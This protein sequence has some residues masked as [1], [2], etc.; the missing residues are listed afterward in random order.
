MANLVQ[1]QFELENQRISRNLDYQWPAS[2]KLVKDIKRSTTEIL[3]CGG[4]GGKGEIP[5]SCS[6]SFLNSAA[7]P[8]RLALLHMA[9]SNPSNSSLL[10]A[11]LVK[12]YS[13][14]KAYGTYSVP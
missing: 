5:D 13:S 10:P 7:P 14:D 2:E 12:V 1:A 8:P 3:E 11:R 9:L 6:N 4:E